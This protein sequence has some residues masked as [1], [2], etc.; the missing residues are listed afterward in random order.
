MTRSVPLLAIALASLLAA[1]PAL[2][3]PPARGKTASELRA[4]ANRLA[5]ELEK[6]RTERDAALADLEAERAAARRALDRVLEQAVVREA[7]LAA[8]QRREAAAKTEIQNAARERERLLA[9]IVTQA[10]TRTLADLAQGRRLAEIVDRL[11][12][13][14]LDR[15][16]AER[17]G[18]EARDRASALS[19]ELATI[20]AQVVTLEHR[21]EAAVAV[22]EKPVD[23]GLGDRVAVLE[24]ELAE[25]RAKSAELER[26]RAGDRRELQALRTARAGLEAALTEAR[27]RAPVVLAAE[28]SDPAASDEDAGELHRQLTLERERRSTL[29][30][31]LVRLSAASDGEDRHGE[32]WRA[33]QSARAEILL[34]T[35]RLQVERTARE[36]LEGLLARA[37]AALPQDPAAD[38]AAL[39]R[40]ITVAENHGRD[41]D[42]LE[43]DLREANDQITRLKGHLEAVQSPD[44]GGAAL[45]A[46]DEENARLTKSLR[47][48]EARVGKLSGQA[49]LA[50]R[51][52]E[53]VYS[54]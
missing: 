26:Q 47:S 10:E 3:E 39:E 5:G 37:R 38:P 44:G 25:T 8:S 18:D 53:L 41:T 49:A 30:T 27:E 34:L 4:Y 21:L 19:T 51:L 23:D 24:A 46:L 45:V 2:A 13:V 36:E 28:Q 48:A 29:E 40:L 20:Q 32:T 6:A 11:R 52:A 42:R 35:E 9:E 17:L 7:E 43:A 15:A 1:G 33:L 50:R 22:K 54:R 12:T 16:E 31:E 14:E